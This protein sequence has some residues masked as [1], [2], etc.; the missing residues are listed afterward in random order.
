MNQI[1]LW[2]HGQ[3]APHRCGPMRRGHRRSSPS[4]VRRADRGRRAGPPDFRAGPHARGWRGDSLAHSEKRVATRVAMPQ[5]APRLDRRRRS[6][7]RRSLR[8]RSLRRRSLR[9]R[10]LRRRSLTPGPPAIRAWRALASTP[11]HRRPQGSPRAP[12]R[13]ARRARGLAGSAARTRARE[14][15]DG[16]SAEE[17]GARVSLG[18]KEAEESV[19]P[20]TQRDSAECRERAPHEAPD[21]RPP[22]K[23]SSRSRALGRPRGPGMLRGGESIVPRS[24]L[25][26]NPSPRVRGRGQWLCPNICRT[27][28]PDGVPRQVASHTVRRLRSRR[29]CSC[30][31][32]RSEER[33]PQD[34][35]KAPAY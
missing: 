16:G 20:L 26:A 14:R 22:Q 8:R 35:P 7:R 19:H 11:G 24:R 6:P 4:L 31:R 1:A 23:A 25:E 27:D 3:A 5:A 33:A 32:H 18:V 29:S 13:W 21:K 28:W 15:A 9:R 2:S 12:L 30:A 17:L 10:S 34:P